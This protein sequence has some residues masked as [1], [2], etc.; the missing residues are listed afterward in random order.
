MITGLSSLIGTRTFLFA[1]GVAE[2]A[3]LFEADCGVAGGEVITEWQFPI[4]D[5]VDAASC[6][7][8]A[9]AGVGVGVL[10]SAGIAGV[11]TLGPVSAWL[12][13]S[14]AVTNK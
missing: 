3:W 4:G 9:G 10:C 8:S 14:G 12:V 7:G 2:A 13:T 6:F 1:W 11:C 5:F